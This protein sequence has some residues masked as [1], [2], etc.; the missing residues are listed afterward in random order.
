MIDPGEGDRDPALLKRL[1]ER[2]PMG[3]NGTSQ[4]VVSAVLYF[5]TCPHYITGQI[6]MVDGGLGLV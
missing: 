3:R 1:A 6:L 4:D 5:A 2:A